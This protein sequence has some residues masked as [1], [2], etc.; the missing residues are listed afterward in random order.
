[1][2]PYTN[3]RCPYPCPEAGWGERVA[4]RY[5]RFYQR[6]PILLVFQPLFSILRDTKLIGVTQDRRPPPSG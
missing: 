2:T 3:D 5:N 6:V 1:M 4:L